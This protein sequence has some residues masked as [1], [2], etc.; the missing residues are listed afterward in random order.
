MRHFLWVWFCIPVFHFFVVGFA[1]QGL[2]WLLKKLQASAEAIQR[3]NAMAM[4]LPME[5]RMAELSH[6]VTRANGDKEPQV[7]Y[8]T[9]RNPLLRWGWAIKH[10]FTS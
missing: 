3:S 2:D 8:R 6:V 1:L 10:A 7:T 5:A 4:M 9:Y